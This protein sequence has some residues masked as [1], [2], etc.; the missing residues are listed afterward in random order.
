VEEKFRGKIE[1]KGLSL[2]AMVIASE[3]I[4]HQDIKSEILNEVMKIQEIW[5]HFLDC[6]I[7]LVNHHLGKRIGTGGTS[8]GCYLEQSKNG[9]NIF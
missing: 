2:K 5:F 9:Q 8:G 7:L 1:G 6:H 3:F 4:T